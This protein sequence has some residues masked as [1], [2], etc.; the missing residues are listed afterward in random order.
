MANKTVS[1]SELLSLTT[2]P[3]IEVDM[4]ELGGVVKVRGLRKSEQVSIRSEATLPNGE[5]DP[6]VIEKKMLGLGLV[7]PEL[8]A[9]EIVQLQQ[10]SAGVYDRL[11]LK[12]AELSGTDTGVAGKSFRPTA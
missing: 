10:L 12:I 6:L 1:A 7:E 3:T 4:P 9:E 5:M 11:L 8:S 2:L